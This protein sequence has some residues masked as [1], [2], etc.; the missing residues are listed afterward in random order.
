MVNNEQLDAGP[1]PP[2]QDD[3]QISLTAGVIYDGHP[4][5]SDYGYVKLQVFSTYNVGDT[6]HCSFVA[7]NPRNNPMQDLSYFYVDQ[8]Q[9]NGDWKTIATDANWETK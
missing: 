6:V 9:E 8:K 7:G 3:K 1:Q 4:I 2:N 5:N